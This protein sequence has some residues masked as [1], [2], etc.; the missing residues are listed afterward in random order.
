MQ[1]DTDSDIP[2]KIKKECTLLW[3]REDSQQV[4]EIL[5]Y[6]E[7]LTE[8][9]ESLEKYE[10][11]TQTLLSVTIADD[12]RYVHCI[13]PWIRKDTQEVI[14]VLSDDKELTEED[15]PI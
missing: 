15:E 1:S 2:L 11:K 14:E 8:V 4:I 10:D 6:E 13:L 9:D 7:E 3:E 12:R 5:D